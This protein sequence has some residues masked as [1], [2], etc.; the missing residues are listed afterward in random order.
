MAVD[1]DSESKG[2]NLCDHGFSPKFI[3]LHDGQFVNL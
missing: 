3:V 2:A 1:I